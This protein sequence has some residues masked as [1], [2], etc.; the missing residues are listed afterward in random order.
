MDGFFSIV[1]A[2]PIVMFAFTCQVNV[3]SIYDELEKG[4]VKRMSKVT[5]GAITTCFLVYL[6]MGLF[7]FWHYG[8]LTQGNVLKNAFPTKDP[9]IIASA[10]CIVLTIVMAF[11][12]VVF[13]CRYTLD[14]ML[15]H[16]EPNTT[17]TTST[18]TDITSDI[19]SEVPSEVTSEGNARSTSTAGTPLLAE[20]EAKHGMSLTNL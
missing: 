9:V 3:F 18:S 16:F 12:L 14:V 8:S 15:R 5:N 6:G 17:T 13:P 1:E 10:V 19:T 2:A 4:N 20:V 7:G 11:P